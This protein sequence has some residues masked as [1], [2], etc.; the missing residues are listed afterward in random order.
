MPL[1]MSTQTMDFNTPLSTQ[2]IQ[3]VLNERIIPHQRYY[4][5]SIGDGASA[6]TVGR[7]VPWNC[8]PHY[9]TR[10]PAL[11][12]MNQDNSFSPGSHW[13]VL[14]FPH[15]DSIIEYFDSLGYRPREEIHRNRDFIYNPI[16]LQSPLSS[17]CGHYCLLFVWY[18]LR[19]GLS[20]RQ[21]IEL[22]QSKSEAE[23]F[24]ESFRRFFSDE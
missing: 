5:F 18:R 22:M 21:F 23:I 10:F 19:V 7:V 4:N 16:P 6:V 1:E 12:V 3:K 11:F 9:I 14:Y 13:T 8:I 15:T 20:M 24:D 2:Q 17:I